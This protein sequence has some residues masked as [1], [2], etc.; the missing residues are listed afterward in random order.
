MHPGT[1]SKMFTHLYRS[2]RHVERDRE[3]YQLSLRLARE[4]VELVEKNQEHNYQ[5][6]IEPVLN[7]LRDTIKG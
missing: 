4:N 2:I 7:R 6:D 5:A 1:K 3:R